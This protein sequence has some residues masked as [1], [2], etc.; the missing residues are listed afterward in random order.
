MQKIT[1]L[2]LLCATSA[3]FATH[4]PARDTSV[5]IP[6]QKQEYFFSK[7]LKS[8]PLRQMDMETVK[9]VGKKA[10]KVAF[11]VSAIFLPS[12]YANVTIDYVSHHL[13]ELG[14]VSAHTIIPAIVHTADAVIASVAAFKCADLFSFHSAGRFSASLIGGLGSLYTSGQLNQITELLPEIGRHVTDREVE[15]FISAL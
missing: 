4:E 8:N 1:A 7:M 9:N 3:A 12:I 14:M 11:Y 6:F 2:V 13:V 10:G 15:E 5:P